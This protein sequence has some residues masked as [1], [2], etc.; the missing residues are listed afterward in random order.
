MKRNLLL[1]I[2]V[3]FTLSIGAAVYAFNSTT[4][5]TN[6]A[7]HSC[8]CKGD[9]CPMKSKDAKASADAK[10]SCC[11]GC[12]SGEGKESCPMM[13]EGMSDEMKKM[14]AE[15]KDGHEGCSCACCGHDEAK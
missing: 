1:A 11:N 8:C 13:K 2:A 12:C 7:S 15:R 4:T 10:D 3:M 5:T 14:H 6:A 9:S